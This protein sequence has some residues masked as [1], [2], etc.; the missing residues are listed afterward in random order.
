[1]GIEIALAVGGLALSAYGTVKQQQQAK[2]S[3]KAQKNAANEQ[4]KLNDAQATRE[5]QKTVREAIRRQA[6]I[7]NSA[8][9]S[10][11]LGSSAAQGGI[12]SLSSEAGNNV[13]YINTVTA[14]N[15]RISDYNVAASSATNRAATYGQVSELGFAAVSNANAIGNFLSTSFASPIDTVTPK[16]N[17]AMS[18]GIY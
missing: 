2:K 7:A 12:G 5:R 9:V 16:M 3:E 18:G 10:G 14:G 4:K 13:G 15:N 8:G 1:M 11:T 6:I 17:A